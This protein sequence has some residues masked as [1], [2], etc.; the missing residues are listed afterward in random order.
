MFQVKVFLNAGEMYEIVD[1]KWKKLDAK[2]EKV[3]VSTIGGQPLMHI[4][5]CESSNMWTKL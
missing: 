1:N 5:N 3:I 4:I 2:A